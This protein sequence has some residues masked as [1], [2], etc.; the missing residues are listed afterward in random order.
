LESGLQG[1]ILPKISYTSVGFKAPIDTKDVSAWGTAY[2]L[3]YALARYP[4]DIA[5][6]GK[7]FERNFKEVEISDVFKAMNVLN[8]PRLISPQ[9]LPDWKYAKE[10][11][12]PIFS[13]LEDA[14]KST[15]DKCRIL[16]RLIKTGDWKEFS[17]S[18]TSNNK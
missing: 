12:L 7:F 10:N 1:N 16:L 5:A 3:V 4:V 18:A 6:S 17:N 11:M 8:D 13:E 2:S 9:H 14:D 15:E